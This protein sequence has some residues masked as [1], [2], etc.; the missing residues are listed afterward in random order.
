MK[1]TLTT[2]L[3][4]ALLLVGCAEDFSF[5]TSSETQI[6]QQSNSPNWIQL[7]DKE[8]MSVENQFSVTEYIDVEHGGELI[9][10]ES[11][12]GG[13]HGEVKVIAKFKIYE[14]TVPEPLMVTMTIDNETG[15]I[16]FSP[17]T[18]FNRSAD[19][20]VKFEGLD[21]SN[22]DPDNVQ[23]IGQTPDNN[24]YPVQYE[25]LD[26]DISSGIIELKVEPFIVDYSQISYNV[27]EIG[28]I[29]YAFVR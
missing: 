7:P 19:L 17:S 6:S 3:L 25:S 20:Y 9:I 5:L 13:P 1:I 8:G 12:N 23:F 26:I 2:L 14:N 15:A 4:S 22:V 21:L 10:D 11:Y 28:G 18:I 27:M 29:R 16:G 24:V